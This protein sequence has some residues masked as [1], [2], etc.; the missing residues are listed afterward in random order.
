MYAIRSY[1]AWRE[2]L[3]LKGEKLSSQNAM[4]GDTIA[5]LQL[6]AATLAPGAS[7]EII[8]VL[9][10]VD[11]E[12]SIAPAAARYADSAAVDKA[13]AD[14]SAYWDSY[15][16]VIRVETPDAAFNSMLNLHNPRQCYTTKAWSRYLSLYQLGYGSDR[17]IGFRDSSQDVLGVIPQ[18][19][20]EARALMEKLISVQSSDGSAYHQFNPLV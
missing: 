3:S 19:P 12:A 14:L 15:L 16:S 4:R 18:I 20:D 11:G 6:R 10:Q 13:F 17:G 1:Y 2:P 7:T 8:T 9:T 5:A